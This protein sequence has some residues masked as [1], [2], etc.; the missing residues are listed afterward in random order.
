M[1]FFDFVAG[2]SPM[3]PL[4]TTPNTSSSLKG[5]GAGWGG[6]MDALAAAGEVIEALPLEGGVAV[7]KEWAWPKF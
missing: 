4:S 6:H 2:K 5:K 3:Q 7:E 1:K